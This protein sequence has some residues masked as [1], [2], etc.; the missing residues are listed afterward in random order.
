MRPIQQL[1]KNIKIGQIINPRLIQAPPDISVRTAVEIMQNNKS[2]YIVIADHQTKVVGIF[3]ETD[4]LHKVFGKKDV[5]TK[6]VS[7]VMTKNPKVLSVRGKNPHQGDL[8]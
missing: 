5:W 1:V 8:R 4:V 2:G 6:P 7:E 3:T